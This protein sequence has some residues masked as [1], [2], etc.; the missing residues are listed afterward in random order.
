M[1]GFKSAS[2]RVYD[3][4]RFVLW[5]CTSPFSESQ[6]PILHQVIPEIHIRDYLD[7]PGRFCGLHTCESEFQ[8]FK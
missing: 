6:H 8:A 4:M 2:R 1:P 5:N 7:V 3:S